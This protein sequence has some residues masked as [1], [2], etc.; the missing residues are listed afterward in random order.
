MWSL[1]NAA[2]TGLVLKPETKRCAAVAAAHVAVVGEQDVG[3]LLL[4][5]AQRAAE[6]VV[7]EELGGLDRLGRGARTSGRR[8]TRRGC[9][10]GDVSIQLMIGP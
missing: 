3:V 2:S 1:R 10:R 9:V 5:A 4:A 8:P 6:G 7:P